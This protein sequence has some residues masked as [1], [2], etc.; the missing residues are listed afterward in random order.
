MD[1]LWVQE[2]S[3]HLPLKYPNRA[4]EMAN[5]SG[6]AISVEKSITVLLLNR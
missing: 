2:M 4:R 6:R 1:G 3:V 5:T